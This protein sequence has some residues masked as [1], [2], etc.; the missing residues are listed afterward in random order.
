MKNQTPFKLSE[1]DFLDSLRAIRKEQKLTQK[2]LAAKAGISLKTV[3]NLEQ[4]KF[5]AKGSLTK[6]AQALNIQIKR[7]FYTKYEIQKL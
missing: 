2:K 4:G 3:I 1:R 7:F 6:V 5:I